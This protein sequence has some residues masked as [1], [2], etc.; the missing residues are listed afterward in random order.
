MTETKRTRI[1]ILKATE[2]PGMDHD[3]DRLLGMMGEHV[4]SIEHTT[5]P[6][7][8]TGEPLPVHRIRFDASQLRDTHAHGMGYR[9]GFQVGLERD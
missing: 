8:Q 9:C 2:W 3:L 4:V 1:E 5:E 7:W 6:H